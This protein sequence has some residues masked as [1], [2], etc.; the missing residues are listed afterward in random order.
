MPG[1]QH[2]GPEDMCQQTRK[3]VSTQGPGKQTLGT[4]AATCHTDSVSRENWHQTRRPEAGPQ[5]GRRAGGRTP[6]LQGGR[7]RSLPRVVGLK[8]G[9]GAREGKGGPAGGTAGG[10]GRRAPQGS[11]VDTNAPPLLPAGLGVPHVLRPS[12][13]SGLLSFYK[14]SPPGFQGPPA[15]ARVWW[16]LHVRA[17]WNSIINQNAAGPWGGGGG[18]KRFPG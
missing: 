14:S 5:G 8:A 7:A 1:S 15:G 18:Q 4:S 10:Q 11:R 6:L 12:P 9:K 13:S 3:R 17:Q 16:R 2:R